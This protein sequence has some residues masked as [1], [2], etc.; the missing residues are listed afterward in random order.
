MTV[1]EFWEKVEPCIF[2]FTFNG[3]TYNGCTKMLDDYG[4]NEHWCSTKVDVNGN[5]IENF[6]VIKYKRTVFNVVKIGDYNRGI[7]DQSCPKSD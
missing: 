5:H 3:V 2:P 7:C 1:G 4:T 6:Q